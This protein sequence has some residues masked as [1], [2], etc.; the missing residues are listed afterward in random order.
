MLVALPV[1]SFNAS[2]VRFAK[3]ISS[4]VQSPIT[5]DHAEHLSATNKEHY[6]S[7]YSGC[8]TDEIPIPGADLSITGSLCAPNCTVDTDCP[9]DA[10]F[11]SPSAKCIYRNPYDNLK[12][13]LLDCLTDDD[14]D[15]A[16]GDKTVRKK[17]AAAHTICA[18]PTNSTRS[19]QRFMLPSASG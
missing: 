16:G 19:S 3:T 1:L 12:Y 2:A 4:D 11:P 17:S 8:M 15:K 7:P 13:C 9:S 18:S 5:H 6:G 10:A 14:C